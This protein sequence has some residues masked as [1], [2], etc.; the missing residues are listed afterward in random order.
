MEEV[1][2]EVEGA[3]AQVRLNRPEKL[4][5]MTD[6]M[7]WAIGEALVSA[8]SDEA[9]R[10]IVVSGEGRAFTSGHD[11]G[12]FGERAEWRP[13]RADRFDT[14]LECAKPTIAAIQGYCL[15]GGLELALFCDIRIA[16]E[17]AQFG[18]PEVHWAILHGYGALRL[19]GMIG[20][21]DA[22]RL[23]LTGQFI[24]AEE[25]LRIGLVSGVTEA[26]GQVAK[27]LEIAEAIA[28]NGPMAVR[29]TKE[30]A[31]RGRDLSLAD[32]LRLYREYSRQAFASSDARE[33]TQAFAMR[34]DPQYGG[35]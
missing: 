35:R 14:G 30:L 26:G 10:C 3:I 6:D 23:L 11:M 31:L 16:D 32:G 4:N 18:C 28:S 29:M 1:I 20:M 5:A 2:Y 17:T 19:P 22:M 33:G 34:R 15:A 21:S 27:A 25:A 8:E 24:D 7:Y 9:V 12:E 13:W